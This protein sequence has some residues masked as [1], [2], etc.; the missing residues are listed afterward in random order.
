MILAL[1]LQPPEFY[2][3]VHELIR[4]CFPDY[5]IFPGES[6][7]AEVSFRICR[8]EADHHLGLSACLRQG[9]Q[10][11]EAE[12]EYRLDSGG[13]RKNEIRR[14]TRVFVYQLLCRHLGK[15]INP[16][17]IL[18]GVRPLKL[19]HRWFDRGDSIEEIL[20]R[21]EDEYCMQPEVARRLAQIAVNNRPF[22]HS[23]QAA[24]KKISIYIGIPFC[25]SQCSYC[26]FPGA[27]L[28]DYRQ[29]IKP[30]L[31]ALRQEIET[32]GTCADE[33]GLEAESIYWGGGT[34]SILAADDLEELFLLL[35]QYH[36]TAVVQETTFEAGRPDTLSL[37]KLKLLRQLGVDRVCINPQTMQDQTLALIQRSH[38][39]SDIVNAVGLAR[40]AGIPAVNM[41]LIVG[42]PEEN[43]EQY[44]DTLAQVLALK[45]ENITVHSLAVKRG[46]RL[47]AAQGKNRL[48]DAAAEVWAGL[49]YMRLMLQDQG[50]LP[51]YLYRQKYMTANVEN[52]GYALP[53]S[54]CRYNIQMMEER[55]TIIGLGGGAGSKF[56]DPSDWSLSNL[57]S[58]KD[59]L[60]YSQHLPELLA[61][62]VD[63]L[64]ALN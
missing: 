46:S 5:Q 44:G 58:P 18:T 29:Q 40:E 16:Y 3:N 13:E 36:M 31:A 9:M 63:K 17:G 26:S 20:A 49:E 4:L 57:H 48:Q 19:L 51:Y 43:R 34:P 25:P 2:A 6:T 10:V 62:K 35:Q 8:W 38:R 41:D 23:P 55:Q 42:L 33:L 39:S 53:G 21:L 24:P 50:Y 27:I 37:E 7:E 15:N 14:L 59:P 45:P 56:V 12:C 1:E 60:A 64:K 52:V 30:F 54:F 22:L 47:D 32:I 11:T 28:T 61:R